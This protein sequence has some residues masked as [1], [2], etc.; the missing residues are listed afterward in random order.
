MTS[1]P[2]ARHWPDRVATALVIAC[3]ALPLLV[4]AGP[5][6]TA[7]AV[8]VATLTL[9]SALRRRRAHRAAAAPATTSL[10]PQTPALEPLLQGILPVWQEHVATV[11]GQTEAAVGDLVERFSAITGQFEAAGF[12]GVGSHDGAGA[13]DRIS[14]LTL[15]E[16]ELQPV[17]ASMSRIADGKDA[18]AASVRELAQVTGELQAM[19]SGVGQIAAQTNLLAINAAIEAARAGVAGR[20][21][22]VIAAEIRR[23][24]HESATTATQITGRMA[25]IVGIMNDAS[26][27]ATKAAVDDKDAIAISGDVVQD[28]LTHVR[29]LSAESQAMLGQGNVIRA[30]IEELIVSLQ[31]QDRVNQVISVVDQDMALLRETLASDARLPSPDEWLRALQSRYTMREQRRSHRTTTSAEPDAA[32]ASGTAAPAVFFF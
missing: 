14:L 15:C 3:A 25:Q 2:P 8:G 24:S 28:V 11:R 5:V 19:A 4:H 10:A 27:A 26:C 23:L 32:P 1:S 12:K 29:E 16:R 17:V 30:N 6:E 22:A 20:G 21:F 13:P 31:F 9:G 7:A 18:M